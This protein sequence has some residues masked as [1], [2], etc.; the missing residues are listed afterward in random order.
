MPW[1]G[2]IVRLA[3]LKN[4]PP[5]VED[6]QTI[7]GGSTLPAS[8]PVFSP[9]GRW[10][11]LLE[12]SGEWEDV[13]LIDLQD[14]SRRVLLSGDGYHL[15]TPDWDQGQRS[16]AWSYDSQGIYSIR[17]YAGTASLYWIGLDGSQ[18]QIDTAPYTWLSQLSVSPTSRQV[19]MIASAP[20]IPTR[21]VRWDSTGL[22]VVARSSTETLDP[23]YLP[24]PQAHPLEC[25]G[26]QFGPRLILPTHPSPLREQRTTSRVDPDPR[27][28]N[29]PGNCRLFR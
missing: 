9:D 22:H 20:T 10:L 1:D 4:D 6:V 23:A 29:L 25:I 2:T 16:L 28:A 17:N 18:K 13:V 26:W 15:C 8:Q 11:A 12:A 19:A 7:A 3:Q 14:G 24:I 5:R 21:I 27:R